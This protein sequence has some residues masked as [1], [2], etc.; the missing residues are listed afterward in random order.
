[1]RRSCRSLEVDKSRANVEKK[2]SKVERQDRQVAPEPPQVGFC[3]RAVIALSGQV[4]LRTLCSTCRLEGVLGFSTGRAGKPTEDAFCP[5]RLLR[6]REQVERRTRG[7]ALCPGHPGRCGTVPVRCPEEDAMR[8][9]SVE[10]IVAA[11]ETEVAVHRERSAYHAGQEAFHREKRS[12]HDAALET[13]SRRLEELRTVA[14]AALEIIGHL[15]PPAGPPDEGPDIGPASKPR[16]T[17]LLKMLVEEL[18][19]DQHFGP[20]WLAAELNR[21]Y[22][23]RLRKPVTA[24]QMSDVC[25][26]LARTGDLRRVR[27]GKG[28][29]ESRFVRVG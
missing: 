22:G 10:E 19:P 27:E 28:S 21:R 20:G 12:H 13:A 25:R 14:A 17:R 7:V 15:A 5:G 24:R 11:L 23:D 2:S 6:N 4:A 16:L 18:G 1:V 8:K 26:R 9:W 29:Y 3:R